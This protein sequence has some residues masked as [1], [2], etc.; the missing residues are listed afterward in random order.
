M[1]WYPFSKPDF[2]L[3]AW[4]LGFRKPKHQPWMVRPAGGQ[5]PRDHSNQTESRKAS[6]GLG[7]PSWASISFSPLHCLSMSFRHRPRDQSDSLFIKGLLEN[8]GDWEQENHVV[9]SADLAWVLAKLDQ[10]QAAQVTV[11]TRP[12]L[13]ATLGEETRAFVWGLQTL[14][15]FSPE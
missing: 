1:Y 8:V 14:H 5:F 4:E 13:P 2:P 7:F 12:A 10:V 9:V 6:W 15:C 3:L 11:E